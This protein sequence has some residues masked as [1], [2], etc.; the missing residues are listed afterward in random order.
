MK[1]AQKDSE[2][3]PIT[4]T[5]ETKEEVVA[6]WDVIISAECKSKEAHQIASQIANW[7]SDFQTRQNYEPTD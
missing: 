3:K 4:I 6:F 2:F 7:F 1:L 5:L